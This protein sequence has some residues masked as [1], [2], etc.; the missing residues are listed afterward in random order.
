MLHVLYCSSYWLILNLSDYY[1]ISL[2]KHFTYLAIQ[3]NHD[4]RLVLEL[5]LV[6]TR[7]T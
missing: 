1:S 5:R 6:V 7:V 2:L 3:Q 4:V